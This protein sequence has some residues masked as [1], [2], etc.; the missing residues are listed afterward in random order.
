MPN[1]FTEVYVHFVWATWDRQPLI[2]PEIELPLC[3][4]I[5]AR[6]RD[7]QAHVLAVGGMQDHIHA[8][9]RLPATLC[10]SEIAREMKGASSHFVTHVLGCS[11]FRWQ[12]SYFASGVCTDALDTVINYIEHQKQHHADKA[13]RVD[14]E[15]P[16]D[17]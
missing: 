16:P 12:G 10:L 17:G 8:L 3:N 7:M 15:L 11:G 6:C 4:C 5:R 2:I 1:S 13:I 14:L 9:V